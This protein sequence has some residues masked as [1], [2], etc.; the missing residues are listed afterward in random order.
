[1]A[2][3][4]EVTTTALHRKM[5]ENECVSITADRSLQQSVC[6]CICMSN[7]FYFLPLGGF[8]TCQVAIANKNLFLMTCL[9][10]IDLKV[11]K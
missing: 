11:T 7:V 8:A 10:K 4:T 1:M 5:A 9:E 3:T 2:E 6:V